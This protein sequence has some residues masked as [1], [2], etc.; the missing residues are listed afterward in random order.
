V[1]ASETPPLDPDRIGMGR[2][3]T[4]LIDATI[5]MLCDPASA[6]LTFE[7]WIAS[8]RRPTASPR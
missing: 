7:C 5:A 3:V 6:F 8:A 2:I 4:E 1:Y